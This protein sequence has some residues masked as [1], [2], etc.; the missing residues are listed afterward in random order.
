MSTKLMQMMNLI[1][2]GNAKTHSLPLIL[3]E[4]VKIYERK[5][6]ASNIATI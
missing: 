1:D 2:K 5:T 4:V 3:I 6:T